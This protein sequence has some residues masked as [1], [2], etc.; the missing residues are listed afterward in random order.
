MAL[1]EPGRVL[2]EVQR[3]YIDNLMSRYPGVSVEL[4]GSSFEERE[5][6]A[7]RGELFFIT[8]IGIYILLAIPLRSYL[9]PLIIMSVIP[10]GIIGAYW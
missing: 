5:S 8:L 2:R 3:N 4:D 10:F 9:Q 6:L 1:T 7:E